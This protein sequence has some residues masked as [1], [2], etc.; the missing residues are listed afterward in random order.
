MSRIILVGKQPDAQYSNGDFDKDSKLC[1]AFVS[2]LNSG[3]HSAITKS[4][5]IDLRRVD[6]V[7][8]G[9][10][11]SSTAFR[12]VNLEV[13]FLEKEKPTIFKEI[14]QFSDGA[15]PGFS[16]DRPPHY[17]FENLGEGEPRFYE[18]QG[19][20]HRIVIDLRKVVYAKTHPCHGD[21][22]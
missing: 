17:A 12:P 1:D 14:S 20:E 16:R 2:Y 9:T 5:V 21:E 19:Y 15:P 10:S 6:A 22:R 18:Y 8:A 13:L 4:I 11:A 3:R 7:E